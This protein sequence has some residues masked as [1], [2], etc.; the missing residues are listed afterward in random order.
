MRKNITNMPVRNKLVKEV[1]GKCLVT[2]VK[3]QS[4]YFGDKVVEIIIWQ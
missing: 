2:V 4:Y 1:L 3:I